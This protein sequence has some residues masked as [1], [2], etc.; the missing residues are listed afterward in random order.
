MMNM[1]GVWTRLF[2]ITGVIGIAAANR[3]LA[4]FLVGIAAICTL[5]LIVYKGLYQGR[6]LPQP[7]LKWLDRRAARQKQGQPTA[8]TVLDAEEF[9]ARLK[10][11]VIGQ[12][13]VID[14][15]ARTL[16][17]RLAA[18]R[19][20]KPLGVFCFAGPPGVGK[21]H[22]AKVVAETLYGDPRH[23]HFIDMTSMVNDA[24]AA[25]LFG[26]PKG[27]AGSDSYGLLP[28]MLRTVPSSVVLLDEFEKAHSDVHKRFL[29]AWNDGFITEASD[30]SKF[31]TSETVFILTTNA[32]ARRIGEMARDHRGTPDEL[33]QMVKSALADSGFAPE[34]LSRIDNVFA[35]REMKGLDIARVVALEIEAITKQYDL[36]IAEGGID[37]QILMRSIE[38]VSEKSVKG[39]VR[40]ISRSIEKQIAD[41]LVD[42][43]LANASRV[44]LVAEG[45][46][47][48]VIAI[49]GESIAVQAGP[50]KSVSA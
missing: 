34:V 46:T 37:P 22:L 49:R 40:E 48:R 6:Y 7:L 29:T 20:N 45:G 9:A 32:Q 11:R 38:T 23:L 14:Q 18:R 3:N 35:F 41:G 36:E 13:E 5:A 44:R 2:I 8:T 43:K 24:S 50:A 27:Y 26:S 17:R 47:V 30:G 16:R 15:L 33:D 39:G 4:Y 1:G 28:S 31:S 10:A 25:T 21:T 19:P 42:A 12:D